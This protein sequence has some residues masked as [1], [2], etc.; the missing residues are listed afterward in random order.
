MYAFVEG[1]INEK[2]SFDENVLP[3]MNRFAQ[4]A[5]YTMTRENY[6]KKETLTEIPLTVSQKTIEKI[7]LLLEENQESS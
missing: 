7:L 4:V 2:K 5:Y 6:T 3:F 1:V